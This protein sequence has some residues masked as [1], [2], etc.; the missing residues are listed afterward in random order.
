MIASFPAIHRRNREITECDCEII[1]Q[2]REFIH[3]GCAP[4]AWGRVPIISARNAMAGNRDVTLPNRD[5]VRRARN[6][7]TSSRD[8]ATRS[9]H[10][11]TSRLQISRPLPQEITRGDVAVD[12][13]RLAAVGQTQ[14]AFEAERG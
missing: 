13:E 3:S 9:R 10:G 1:T 2:G 5:S 14:A 6:T 7:T 11:D 4:E 12:A 8:P